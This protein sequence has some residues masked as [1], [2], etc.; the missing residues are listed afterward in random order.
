MHIRVKW[1]YKN[2]FHRHTCADERGVELRGIVLRV[3]MQA[4][5]WP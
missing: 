2:S 4:C 3:Y 1:Y 5:L